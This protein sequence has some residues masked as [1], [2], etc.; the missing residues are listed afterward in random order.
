MKRGSFRSSVYDWLEILDILPSCRTSCTGLL[1]QTSD[2]KGEGR[3]A[4]RHTLRSSSEG[5]TMSETKKYEPELTAL[6][7]E[8]EAREVERLNAENKKLRETLENIDSMAM[9]PEWRNEPL[10]RIAELTEEALT[11]LRR[12]IK[13][14]HYARQLVKP[15]SA[16]PYFLYLFYPN[17]MWDEY[18]R[19]ENE[20]F[21][22]Y[23]PD[24]Y[25][26]IEIED[27]VK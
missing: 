12:N 20:A 11:S 13:T 1:D 16:T 21:V 10:W 19:T 25:E 23:P 14:I 4:G 5:G 8:V 17:G 2:N 24:S 3:G 15:N 18:K 22:A 27:S 7:Y 6:L 26:W 9:S